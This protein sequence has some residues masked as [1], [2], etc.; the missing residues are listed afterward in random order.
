MIPDPKKSFL[1][2]YTGM[3]NDFEEFLF[4][5]LTIPKRHIILWASPNSL[6]NCSSMD[7]LEYFMRVLNEASFYTKHLGLRL[8]IEAERVPEL[9]EDFSR[10][11]RDQIIKTI[12]ENRL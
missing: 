1:R 6:N 4:L 12:K 3:N 8:K 5:D 11:E 7:L 10:E 2:L 9:M